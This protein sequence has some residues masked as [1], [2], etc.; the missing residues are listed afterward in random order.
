MK[1]APLVVLLD[2]DGTLVGDVTPQ[3]E[4]YYAAGT[5]SEG[6][7][8]ARMLLA[9]ALMRGLLRPHTAD[10]LRF[11]R[12]SGMEVFVYT[13]AERSWALHVVDAIE[14]VTGFTFNRPVF[15]RREC[16]QS[17]SGDFHK[18]LRH[19][20][21]RV[22]RALLRDHPGLRSRDLRNRMLLI[23]NTPGI[24]LHSEKRGMV[25]VPTYSARV[26]TSI[27]FG[28]P[29]LPPAAHHV[30][31][32]TRALLQALRGSK[33]S[34]RSA[35]MRAYMDSLGRSAATRGA[36]ATAGDSLWPQL[37]RAMRKLKIEDF[38]R[39]TVQ[40]IDTAHFQSAK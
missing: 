12:R 7:A 13:S 23:D 3:V 6:R 9:D 36:V 28:L 38:G 8:A 1:A 31:A 35:A 14:R 32:L 20:A 10:F 5:S 11:L 18:S 33:P 19:T 39:T 30:A 4:E 40:A 22:S 16:L 21:P 27:T 37:Q 15:S 29:G 34:E 26:S 2:V 24:L 25:L 17:R